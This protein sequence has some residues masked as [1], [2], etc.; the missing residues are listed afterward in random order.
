MP[1]EVLCPDCAAQL[2]FIDPYLACPTCGAPFGA[3]VCTEC[4]ESRERGKPGTRPRVAD[5]HVSSLDSEPQRSA[6]TWAFDAARCALEYAGLGKRVLTTYKDRDEIRL[7]EH[8]AACMLRVMRGSAAIEGVGMFAPTKLDDWTQWAEALVA[9]PA[10]PAAIRRRG[11]DHMQ[12]IA[13]ELE[14]TSGLP[15]LEP[16]TAAKK[17]ADQRHLGSKE[18]AINLLGAFAPKPDASV[19][20]HVLL[21]D[22]VLTT[23][24]TAH[25]AASALLACGATHV[26]VVTFARVW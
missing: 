21:I 2:P 26:R 14:K 8:I 10:T 23:G 4:T 15:L 6:R 12:L 5:H 3:L 9:I 18:R 17:T 24:A 22:D 7:A 16:L 19:P 11:Y 13:R 20:A 25:A 1:G